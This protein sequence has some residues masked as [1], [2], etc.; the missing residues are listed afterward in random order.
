MT[1]TLKRVQ[2]ELRNNRLKTTGDPAESPGTPLDVSS[3]E[4][5]SFL[6]GEQFLN[7]GNPLHST[8]LEDDFSPGLPQDKGTLSQKKINKV[9]TRRAGQGDVETPKRPT[10]TGRKP[11]TNG[12]G[13][14]GVQQNHSAQQNTQRSSR[15]TGTG[16]KSK[17]RPLQTVLEDRPSSVSQTASSDET[18]HQSEDAN[19]ASKNTPAPTSMQGRPSLSS[20]ELTDEDASFHPSSKKSKPGHGRQTRKS[21]STNREPRSAR[22]QNRK[23]S[24]GSSDG[25][26]LTGK[27]KHKVRHERNPTDLD[28]VLDSFQD[29][30]SEYKKTVDSD[31]VNQAIDAL[32]SSFGDQLTETITATKEL[33]NIKRKNAKINRAI[34]LKRTKLMEAKNE[35]IKSEAHMRRLQKGRDELEQRLTDLRKAWSFLSHLAKLHRSYLQHCNTHP[36]EEPVYGPSCM[37]ALLLEARGMLGAEHQPKTIN[38]KLQQILDQADSK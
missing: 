36:D 6:Q 15:Q 33:G 19:T 11:E 29:F 38:E 22:E 3:I 4:K 10:H 30:V 5:A 2:Q 16:A 9:K 32:S 37:P 8:A 12:K 35:L 24:S 27:Q 7:H 34:N 1:K 18:S 25:G 28:V 14:G 20:E 26:G 23:S 13:D 31:T 17:A 21:L